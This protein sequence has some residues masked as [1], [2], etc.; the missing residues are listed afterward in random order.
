MNAF[1]SR[2]LCCC[3]IL[4]LGRAGFAASSPKLSNNKKG[5]GSESAPVLMSKT[6]GG[7][8]WANMAELQ[9]A[10]NQGNVHAQAQLGERLLRGEDIAPDRAAGLALLEKAARAGESSAAFRIGMVLDDG[11]G[12][13]QDRARALAYFRAAAA[14]GATEAFYNVGAAYASARGVKR[15]YV[16]GLAW[17]MLG[18]KRGAP[19][20]GE[21]AVRARLQ[22]MGHPE[23]IA[24]AE[25]RVPELE[26]ELSAKP[27]TEFLPPPA[28]FASLTAAAK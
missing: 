3:G 10:A 14:G 19:R 13:P 25:K 24:A 28:P 1:F 26:R 15:D 20:E 6:A 11:D 5:N 16:E 17:L 7:T 12:V 9:K 27:A 4:F 2:A 21:D 18:T 23:M 22:K 8:S